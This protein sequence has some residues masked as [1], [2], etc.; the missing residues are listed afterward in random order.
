MSL[1][2]S[3][4]NAARLTLHTIV[5][6]LLF[7]IGGIA[8]AQPV[9]PSEPQ[10]AT[11][12]ETQAQ[13]PNQAQAAGDLVLTDDSIRISV[14]TVWPGEEVH[15]MWGHT[16]IRVQVFD[17]QGQPLDDILYNYGTFDFDQPYFIL[18]FLR[19][20][21]DY[22]LTRASPSLAL[23]HYRQ[24][25]RG[26]VE[27]VLDLTLQQE[28][29]I[30][31]KLETNAL[32]ENREY[33]YEFMFDNCSTRVR[34]V[35]PIRYDFE[36]PN[37]LSPGRHFVMG[38]VNTADLGI[39]FKPT[40]PLLWPTFREM[41]LAYV[42]EKPLLYTGINLIFGSPTDQ[43]VVSES[44]LFLPLPLYE[45]L[46][47]A[48][49]IDIE[50]QPTAP[51]TFTQIVVAE[52]PLVKDEIILVPT[53]VVK[54]NASSINTSIVFDYV[55]VLIVPM[56]VLSLVLQ[57]YDE[58]LFSKISSSMAARIFEATLLGLVGLGG[59]I[60]VLM[61]FGTEHLAT[62]SNW[63]FLLLWPTHLLFA[64]VLF[65]WPKS[66]VSHVYREAVMWGAVPALILR[67]AMPQTVSLVA[68]TALLIVPAIGTGPNRKK[69]ANLKVEPVQE[70]EPSRVGQA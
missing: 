30:I 36:T 56:L 43:R 32:L 29:D 26:V 12:S 66:K 67:L 31:E 57:V 58:S 19:G 48:A 25:N 27:Q 6:S 41:M 17:N 45:A 2:L 1:K 20:Q 64:P 22:M 59:W 33:R 21:L 37:D 53:Q 47:A 38:A 55:W 68:I 5:L 39:Q 52:K 46:K 34:D 23:D 10:E 8:A 14:W 18:K 13:V 65:L 61:W 60:I 24:A 42:A 3:I 50:K 11:L 49:I 40:E 54:T 15:A 44:A 51:R 28:L 62:Q 35:L 9:E 70:T 7:I 16:A 63:N 69:M 4:S